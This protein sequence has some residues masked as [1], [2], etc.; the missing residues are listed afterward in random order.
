MYLKINKKKIQIKEY[1]KF[2]DRIKSL[3]FVL[4]KIDYGIKLPNK[5]KASTYFFCQRVD[6]CFTDKEDNIIFLLDNVKT[7]KKFF[8][9]KAKNI[10]YLPLDTCN[11]LKIGERL[12]LIKK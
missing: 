5:K 1:N 4:E 11:H 7:E 3:K 10:Y 6:I 12:K 9:F 2:I 8:K